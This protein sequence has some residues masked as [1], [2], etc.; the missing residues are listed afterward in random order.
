MLLWQRQTITCRQ[1]RAFL[2]SPFL[3]AWQAAPRSGA[4]HWQVEGHCSAVPC[5]PA[6]SL[7]AASSQL[8]LPATPEARIHGAG[9][10]Q[11]ESIAASSDSGTQLPTSSVHPTPFLCLVFLVPLMKL[12][13]EPPLFSPLC[14]TAPIQ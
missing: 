13:W 10:A 6:G 8:Q 1:D 4:Q 3:L 5:Q 9:K 12:G 2:Q 11:L 14:C 7:M